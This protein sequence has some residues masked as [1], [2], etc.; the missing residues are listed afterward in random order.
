M[1]HLNQV[2]RNTNVKLVRTATIA[3]VAL[4]MACSCSI[5]SESNDEPTGAPTPSPTGRSIVLEFDGTVENVVDNCNILGW[6][7]ELCVEMDNNL[8]SIADIACSESENDSAF[9]LLLTSSF[10]EIDGE[11]STAHRILDHAE[12]ICG[13]DHEFAIP[14]LRDQINETNWREE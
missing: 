13:N 14:I 7:H 4:L 8:E 12:A 6:D 1:V 5:N 10:H 9:I 3:V 11:K 2:K